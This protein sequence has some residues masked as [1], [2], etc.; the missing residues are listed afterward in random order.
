MKT[1]SFIS[2]LFASVTTTSFAQL[3]KQEPKYKWSISAAINSVEA[4]V[5]DPEHASWGY[6]YAN[7]N[8]FGDKINKSLS[9]SITPK[10][11]INENMLAR[12]EFGLTNINL[13]SYYNAQTSS[14]NTNTIIEYQT[15]EQKIYR[16]IPGIQWNFLRKKF[17][18]SYC[19]ITVSY[20]HYNHMAYTNRFEGRN[21]QSNTLTGGFDDKAIAIGGF[22]MGGGAFMGGNIYLQKHISVGAEFSTSLLYYEIG[23][24]FSGVSTD[25]INPNPST[26]QIYSYS[27]TSY[28]GFQF[29]KILSS[30]N[31]S[32]WF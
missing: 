9:L 8:N 16:Y 13:S 26:T 27:T 4:Q 19:G 22:A 10:Y 18:E 31:I 11:F 2:L 7:F 32:I 17:I 30:F 6:A 1:K 25:L 24:T 14:S 28:K 15:I 5:G 21:L 29:S 12:F 3:E 20:L 23:D